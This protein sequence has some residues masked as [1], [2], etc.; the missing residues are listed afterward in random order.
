MFDTPPHLFFWFKVLIYP[1]L[2][3]QTKWAMYFKDMEKVNIKFF[4]RKAF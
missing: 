1:K 4:P 2:K 3:S